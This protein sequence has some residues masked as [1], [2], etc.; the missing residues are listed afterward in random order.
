MHNQLEHYKTNV[1]ANTQVTINDKSYFLRTISN[2]NPKLTLGSDFTKLFCD[3]PQYAITLKTIDR[4]NEKTPVYKELISADNLSITYVF[5]PEFIRINGTKLSIVE[6]TDY[7][8]NEVSYDQKYKPINNPINFSFIEGLTKG[9]CLDE[10]I[11]ELNK[12]KVNF[13]GKEHYLILDISNQSFEKEFNSFYGINDKF[14]PILQSIGSI[15]NVYGILINA[16]NLTIEHVFNRLFADYNF[17]TNQI[18]VKKPAEG[19]ATYLSIIS[20]G[21]SIIDFYTYNDKEVMSADYNKF[22]PRKQPP[23]P[24]PRPIDPYN[25]RA[26][27]ALRGTDK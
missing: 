17:S 6:P 5:N 13:N 7:L 4:M 21:L 8:A 23:P 24:P 11:L 26:L 14:S 22:A 27:Y 15:D 18:D 20:K 25:V 16:D 2:D 19:I 3:T 10:F 12:H 9:N 1:L